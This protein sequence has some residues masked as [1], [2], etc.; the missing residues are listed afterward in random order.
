MLEERLRKLEVA[1]L[2]L[3]LKTKER[4]KKFSHEHE[5]KTKVLVAE[6]QAKLDRQQKLHDQHIAK[7]HKEHQGKLKEAYSTPQSARAKPTD[8]L[9]K[10]ERLERMLNETKETLTAEV[11]HL[12]P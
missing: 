11:R 10:A 3:E 4:E 6:W 7:L 1:K 9:A 8:A 12:V 5:E 2:D